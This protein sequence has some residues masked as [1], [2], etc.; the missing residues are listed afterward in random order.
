MSWGHN[1]GQQGHVVATTL[2]SPALADLAD[3]NAAEIAVPVYNSDDATLE[4]HDA[5]QYHG[6]GFL[7][8][9]AVLRGDRPEQREHHGI[10]QHRVDR[11][12]GVR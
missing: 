6:H 12:R 11:L 9:L 7:R 4:T 5:D 10:G 1:G 8:G 3:N 2:V